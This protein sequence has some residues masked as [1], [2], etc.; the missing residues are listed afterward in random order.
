MISRVISHDSPLHKTVVENVM[1][2][3]R[4]ADTVHGKRMVRWNKA[5][6]LM[7]AAVPE[8]SVD[9]QRKANRNAGMPDYTT[10][11]IPYTYAAI[12]AAYS[13][14]ST[15]FLARAP[16]HQ[17]GGRHGESEQ[18]QQALEALIA[19]QVQVGMHMGPYYTAF[20]DAPKYGEYVV[21]I[22]W[23]E[24][25]QYVSEI[26]EEPE[27][28]MGIE[29]PGSLKKKKRT[30]VIP[31]YKG[32][33]VFNISPTRFMTDPRV[34]RMRFQE[35]EFC[36][37]YIE[38]GWNEILRGK[39]NGR[40][41]NLD[42]LKSRYRNAAGNYGGD[43]AEGPRQQESSALER[44]DPTHFG[45][46]T[47]KNASDVLRAYEVYIEL[48]PSEWGLGKSDMPEKWVF[49]VTYDYGLCFEA[50]PLGYIHNKFPFAIGTVEP[51]AYGI[52]T[53]SFVDVL[54]PVQNTIDWL[55][56]SHYYNVRQMLNGV[57]IGDPSRIEMRDFE[58][59]EPGKMIRLKPSAYGSNVRDVI[60]QM[61]TQDV[62][63]NHL[64]DIEFMYQV[65]E[66][67]GFN[68]QV[69]GVGSPT[70]RRSAAEFRGTSTF[71]VGRLK[72]TSEFISATAWAGMQTQL[73]SNTQQYYDDN[74]KIRLVGDLAMS[75]GQKFMQVTPEDIAG[76]YDPV[77][78]DGTLPADRY[79]QGNLWREL[80]A[81]AA[82]IPDVAMQYDMGKIF[83]WVAQ[84][85]GIKNITQFARQPGINT[86]IV[87]D[88]VLAQQVAAGN[89][90]GLTQ[91]DLGNVPEPGQLTGM[92]PT[93]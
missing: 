1:W 50:R 92:G 34:P 60:T 7:I 42:K 37:Q 45:S 40:Y 76:F 49:T 66:R 83:A 80:M 89:S 28:W 48:I 69:L 51:E 86:Q 77:L 68:D 62:T 22:Y 70:S 84:L 11:Q 57:Y 5:E 32:N 16:V 41:F 30:R 6:N 73:V 26:I 71:S 14:M 25:L 13:Y 24:E 46:S 19:Y 64:S 43:T 4:A 90:V 21:G 93:G 39:E 61:Q 20:Y 67:L 35:G 53:R 8:S 59:R 33:K 58:R 10:V 27:Y 63:Q 79:A 18:Q 17:F 2:R 3:I 87:P 23:K 75:A 47:V 85:M 72:T 78:I 82:Q 56:N 9:K 81:Q 52:L 36:A 12:M 65:G 38:I 29:I 54:E 88:D 15:V 31:G 44:P 55:L 74:M 91:G